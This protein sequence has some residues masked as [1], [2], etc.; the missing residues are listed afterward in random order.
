[1]LAT[2]STTNG[3]NP[4]QASPAFN[5]ELQ[6]VIMRMVDIAG[7]KQFVG[8]LHS[9]GVFKCSHSGSLG[10]KLGD[11]SHEAGKQNVP[12]ISNLAASENAR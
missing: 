6:P 2:A 12:R 3:P 10:L 5:Q 11:H 4:S 9:E 8:L 7:T 1:M